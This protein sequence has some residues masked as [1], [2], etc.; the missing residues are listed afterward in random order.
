[1]CGELDFAKQRYKQ[2][3]LDKAAQ[4]QEIID[5]KLKPKGSNPFKISDKQSTKEA[6]KPVE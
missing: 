6:K 4:R 2:M 1:M 3:Q 5:N